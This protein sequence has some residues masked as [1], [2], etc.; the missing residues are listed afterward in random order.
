MSTASCSSPKLLTHAVPAHEAVRTLKAMVRWASP[1]DIMIWRSL[2]SGVA[3]TRNSARV[4]PSLALAAT[5][6]R[7]EKAAERLAG[8]AERVTAAP[9]KAE[10]A[11]EAWTRTEAARPA[12]R[13]AAT[14]LGFG[15][16]FD[17]G[18]WVL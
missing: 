11:A 3:S 12:A 1:R 13:G 15:G 6:A 14:A 17:L 18:L 9:E 2:G 16:L 4:S 7:R 8:A 5:A 10:R